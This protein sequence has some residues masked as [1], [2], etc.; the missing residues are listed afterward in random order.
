MPKAKKVTVEQMGE[1]MMKNLHK[2]L[3]K[4][5]SLLVLERKTLS[6]PL[7][8]ADWFERF[9]KLNANIRELEV[10]LGIPSI[11]PIYPRRSVQTKK[12]MSSLDPRHPNP[13]PVLPSL[14]SQVVSLQELVNS[15][16]TKVDELEEKLERVAFI[17]YI[18][19]GA[20]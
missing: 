5:R 2:D 17:D 4:K 14:E 18:P 16:V 19:Q 1:A 9:D 11:R 12:K 13:D 3:L 15:L 7:E 8:I 6:K 20:R 10:Q